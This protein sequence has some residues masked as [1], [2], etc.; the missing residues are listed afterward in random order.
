MTDKNA[1]TPQAEQHHPDQPDTPQYRPEQADSTTEALRV[2]SWYKHQASQLSQRWEERLD[3]FELPC[4]I[5]RGELIFQGARRSPLFEFSEG[6]PGTITPL[7]LLAL[8]FACNRCGYTA[9]FDA[10]LFNPSHLAELQ[11]AAPEKVARLSVPNFRI[12]VPLTGLEK[13]QTLLDLASSLAGERNAE[14]LALNVSADKAVNGQLSAKLQQYRP[15]RGDP[16]VMHLL[17]EQSEDVGEAIV[18][19]IDR[20]RCD[21]LLIGWRGWSRQRGVIMGTVLDTV[22]NEATCDVA[23]IHDRGLPQIRR[24]LL[25]TA[26]GPNTDSAMRLAFDLARAHEADLDLVYVISPGDSEGEKRGHKYLEKALENLDSDYHYEERRR[27]VKPE[28]RIMVGS[29]FV[30]TIVAEAASYDLLLIGAP[31]RTWRGTLRLNDK[32]V[33]I[34]RNCVPTAIVISARHNRIGSWFNRI[35]G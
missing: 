5:C 34:A 3:D 7:N 31:H 1:K 16:A 9:E 18:R 28:T 14:V 11:G 17:R 10:E 8:A 21:L 20:Q 35:L 6:E 30:Q 33:R 23:V 15:E 2:E 19:A 12:L 22:L 26:G 4:P 29:D 27:T 32:V 25:P 13:N 24:I